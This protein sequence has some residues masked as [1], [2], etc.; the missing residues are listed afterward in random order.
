MHELSLRANGEPLEPEAYDK[1]FTEDYEKLGRHGGE[2]W[3]LERRQL[4][5]E[6]G[7]PSWH[8]YLSGDWEE[9]LRLAEELRPDLEQEYREDAARGIRTRWTKVVELPMTPFIQWAF[10]PLRVRAQS[11]EDMRVVEAEKVARFERDAPLPEVVTLGT[12]VMYEVLYTDNGEHTGAI[13][14]EDRSTIA[15]CRR[16]MADLHEMGEDFESFYQRE[17]AHLEPPRGQ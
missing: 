13:R 4:F 7:M 11:G 14:T 2:F 15:R 9:A 17:V 5:Q 12:D 10:H 3:K 8:A 1:K 16:L 6:P